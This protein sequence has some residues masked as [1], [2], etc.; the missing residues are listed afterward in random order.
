[1]ATTSKLLVSNLFSFLLSLCHIIGTNNS[2]TLTG[3]YSTVIING[4]Y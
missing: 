4:S 1:M 3:N 2:V